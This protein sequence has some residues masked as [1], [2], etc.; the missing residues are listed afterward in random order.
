MPEPSSPLSIGERIS[1]YRR[2]RGLTQVVLAGLVGR[3]TSWLQKVERGDRRIDRISVVADIARVLRVS[4]QDL[5]GQPYVFDLPDGPSLPDINAIRRMLITDDPDTAAPP[6]RLPTVEE[7]HAEARPVLQA[8]YDARL[9]E[10]A[11]AA[12]DLIRDCRLAAALAEG[13]QRAQLH[14][15]LA[16]LYEAIWVALKNLGYVDLAWLAIERG[17]D[18]A[19]QS[20]DPLAERATNFQVA[21]FH[22]LIGSYDKAHQAAME[23]ADPLEADLGRAGPEHRSVY[24]ALHLAGAV[25]AARLARPE[26]AQASLDEAATA[27]RLLGA[28]RNDYCLH[29]GPTNVGIHRVAVAVEMAEGGRAAELARDVDPSPIAPQRQGHHWIAVGRAY[30]QKHSDSAAVQALMRAEQVA[31]VLVR[32]PPIVREVV[33]DLLRRE[34]RAGNPDL[35]GLA[36]RAGV[37]N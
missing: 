29:F 18:A 6:D 19:R 28:D 13:K 12:P 8:R 11:T 3:S 14:R 35:R 23:S 9:L 31:P 24:G 27:G 20:A 37:L 25:A 34:R 30:A 7:L 21:Q 2:R 5:T 36:E 22:M 17:R 33:A 1:F 4:P 32:Y 16:D 15:L 10:V 26:A